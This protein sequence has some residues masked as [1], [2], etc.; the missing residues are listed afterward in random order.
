MSHKLMLL[1]MQ[2]QFNVSIHARQNE[3]PL[4]YCCTAEWT[5][6]EIRDHATMRTMELCG[7]PSRGGRLAII[8]PVRWNI[9]ILS[10]IRRRFIHWKQNYKNSFCLILT[11]FPELDSHSVHAINKNMFIPSWRE[12]TYIIIIFII[13]YFR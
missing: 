8:H 9:I 10:S 5:T 12:T 7:N 13:T 6:I 4:I 1:F 3:T 11:Q 2:K